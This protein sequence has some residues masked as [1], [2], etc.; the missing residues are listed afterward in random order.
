MIVQEGAPPLAWRPAPLHHVFGDAWLSDGKA[1]LEQFAVNAWRPP[2][3]VLDAHSPDQRAS[4]LRFAG[5]LPV[6]VISTASS[7]ESPP[8][9][10]SPA[11]QAGQSL[12]PSRSMETI[13]TSGRGTSG[14]CW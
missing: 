2:K 11:S 1:E 10:N 4:P 7:S 5:A 8:G 9:A 12:R 13:D 14:R 3:R 6:A